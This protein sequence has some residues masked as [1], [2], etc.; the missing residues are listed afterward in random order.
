MQ[1]FQGVPGAQD[2]GL[3]SH[4][5]VGQGALIL[6]ASLLS[7]LSSHAAAMH[8]MAA[9]LLGIVCVALYLC[10]AQL[11]CMHERRQSGSVVLVYAKPSG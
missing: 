4:V 9:M 11:H 3:S 6:L 10:G 7:L 8:C 1:D 5:S 2:K